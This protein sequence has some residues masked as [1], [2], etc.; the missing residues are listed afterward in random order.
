MDRR[1]G[2]II[3]TI[4]TVLLCGCPGLFGICW[5]LIAAGAAMSGGSVDIGG[6]SDP[7]A[8]IAIGLT[9][10]ILGLIFFAIPI[11]IGIFTFRQPASPRRVVD[12][13][14]PLPPPG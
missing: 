5:G 2:G 3:A 12:A 8:A 7:G 9:V 6:S 14:E 11:G 1:T 10:F 13:D 4:V